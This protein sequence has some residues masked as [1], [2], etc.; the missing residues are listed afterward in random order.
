M[1]G[2]APERYGPPCFVAF[3][4][5]FRVAPGF[6]LRIAIPAIGPA[7]LAP[8]F[9]FRVS[10]EVTDDRQTISFFFGASRQ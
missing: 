5:N 4:D 10:Y 2:I 8:D 3:R 6:G 7:P 1:R 9:A